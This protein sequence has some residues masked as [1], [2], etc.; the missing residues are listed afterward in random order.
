MNNLPPKV[1]VIVP[2]Y[3][4]EKYIAECIDSVLA[5][6]Y[7]NL[8]L[9]L[10]NDGSKDG[11]G[12]ICDE[13]AVKDSRVRVF[14]KENK[15]VSFA[16]NLGLDNAIGD[17]IIFL[18]SDD[19]W[20]TNDCLEKLVTTSL[21]FNADIVRGQYKEVDEIG[22]D[23][24]INDFSSKIKYEMRI[25]SSSVFYQQIV[26]GENFFVLLLLKKSIF[27]AGLRF[28][29]KIGFQEDAELNI[30]L[31]CENYR[32]I[33]I[34]YMFYAYRK[35]RNSAVNSSKISYLNDA[36]HLSDIFEKYSNITNDPILKQ[37]YRE[38]AV[39][40]YYWT[41][42]TIAE[43]PY[44]KESRKIIKQLNLSQRRKK[45]L[46]WAHKYGVIRKSYIFN[47]LH[48]Y[49]SILLFRLRNTL[50]AK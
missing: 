29:E 11:S 1:S 23:L 42:V 47:C 28:D 18:D 49:I 40:M 14:H 32:C 37:V 31:F 3:N 24:L 2:V 9:L 27:D 45:I 10:I 43:D 13:Y 41:L 26:N 7:S 44:Y 25:L 12:A 35:R 17:Y 19:Y 48:P 38:N 22:N 16:R 36:F 6:S 5:Q 21:M 50:L 4:V 39:M 8:E 20:L 46:R 33:Y 34:S 15:G 30:R